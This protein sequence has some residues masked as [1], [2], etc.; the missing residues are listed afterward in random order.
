MVRPELEKV[1]VEA[2]AK[3]IVCE[4]SI[5][6]E[7]IFSINS[8]WNGLEISNKSWKFTFIPL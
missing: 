5:V 2:S 7:L 3:S 1:G 8:I 6:P 4:F